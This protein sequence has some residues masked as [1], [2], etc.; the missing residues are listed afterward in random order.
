[1]LHRSMC[2]QGVGGCVRH[3]CIWLK[4]CRVEPVV[5]SRSP[6]W[7]CERGLQGAEQRFWNPAAWVQIPVFPVT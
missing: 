5:L 4:V 1:M 3:L 2:P 7:A 6:G